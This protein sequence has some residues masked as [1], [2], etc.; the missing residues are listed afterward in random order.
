MIG[1]TLTNIQS[2]LLDEDEFLDATPGNNPRLSPQATADSQLVSNGSHHSGSKSPG[3]SKK[4]LQRPPVV[5]PFA[6][7]LAKR[8]LIFSKQ[9]EF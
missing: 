8:R 9:G 5:H 7:A 1:H 3:R 6:K 4:Y 2:S